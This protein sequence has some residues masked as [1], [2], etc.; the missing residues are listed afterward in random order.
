M[1]IKT[2]RPL[3]LV[4]LLG[5]GIAVQAGE[6][7]STQYRESGKWVSMRLCNADRCVWRAVTGSLSNGALFAIDFED[8]GDVSVQMF[9]VNIPHSVMSQWNG[10]YDAIRADVRVDRKTLYK[11]E[12]LRNLERNS[13]TLFYYFPTEELGKKFISELK[14]GS[15]LRVRTHVNNST[16]INEYSLKGATAA[17]GR[18]ERNSAKVRDS[19]SYFEEDP[20]SFF[21]ESKT[22]TE[23]HSI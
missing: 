3:L 10:D 23:S 21:D 1:F 16:T 6:A 5:L 12:V 11:V 7:H 17:I 20:E 9:Q 18:A 2:V 4:A 19:N 8:K 14:Q 13:R 22:S 15:M